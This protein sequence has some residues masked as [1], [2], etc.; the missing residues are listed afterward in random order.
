MGHVRPPLVEDQVKA[1]AQPVPALLD[2]RDA[3]VAAA[4]FQRDGGGRKCFLQLADP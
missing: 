1:G 4:D 2:R 3:R